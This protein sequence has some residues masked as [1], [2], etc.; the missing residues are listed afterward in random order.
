MREDNFFL[1]VGIVHVFSCLLLLIL[2]RKRKITVQVELSVI[3][4]LVPI[5]GAVMLFTTLY[6]QKKGKIGTRE[7]NSDPFDLRTRISAR[8]FIEEEL[9]SKRIMSLEEAL[10]L[11]DPRVRRQLMKTIVQEDPR[12]FIPVLQRGR[13]SEDSEVSHY[14]SAAILQLQTNYE[15]TLQKW[16]TVLS[17]EKTAENLKAYIQQLQ[18]YLESDLLPKNAAYSQRQKLRRAAE[19]YLN[20]DPDNRF[21]YLNAVENILELGDYSLAEKQLEEAGHRWKDDERTFLLKLKL[22]YLQHNSQAM[23]AEVERALETNLYLSPAVRRNIAF[24]ME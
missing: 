18:E 12:K 8:P 17:Q 6:Y 1:Y 24:W 16:E 2:M 14:A 10:L 22:Y 13:L 5:W 15:V 23:R 11:E 21:I 19:E 3:F 4:L 7:I 9:T 20:R